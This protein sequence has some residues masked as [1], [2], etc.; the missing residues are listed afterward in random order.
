[1]TRSAFLFAWCSAL[2]TYEAAC[3]LLGLGVPWLH[4]VALALNLAALGLF[5]RSALRN[6]RALRKLAALNAYARA[7]LRVHA[8]VKVYM[9]RCDRGS[10][11][12]N[13][14]RLSLFDALDRAAS[15]KARLV[16]EGV[17]L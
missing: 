16:G 14:T 8:W 1:M 6:R 4:A 12:S 5:L 3:L 9:D 2:A 17:L 11:L 15:E 13:Q 10:P 7:M